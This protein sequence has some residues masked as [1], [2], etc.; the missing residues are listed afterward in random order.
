MPEKTCPFCLVDVKKN[1]IIYENYILFV[2]PSNPWLVPG[3][4]LI[5]PK[6]HVAEPFLL[7]RRERIEF[8]EVA[9]R[10]QQKL[11]ELFSARWGTRASCD[12]QI[13]PKPFMEQTALAITGHTHAHLLPRGY[14]DHLWRV[15][16]YLTDEAFKNPSRGEL[17][18][19]VA[20]LSD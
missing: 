2:T 14:K 3:H 6:R 5:I 12:L 10:F 4:T 7:G 16:G 15:S 17:D 8:M 18:D 19:F 11:S 13:L 1:P 20:S 9:F